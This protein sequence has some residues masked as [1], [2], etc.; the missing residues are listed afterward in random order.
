V[1]T[2]DIGDRGFGVSIA[3]ESAHKVRDIAKPDF[4]ICEGRSP[5]SPVGER[6][7]ETGVGR[8]VDSSGL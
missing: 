1:L 3:R 7:P 2:V 8:V 4:P 5:R 6:T